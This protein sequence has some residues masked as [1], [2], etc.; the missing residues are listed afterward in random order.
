MDI[1]EDEVVDHSIAIYE[2]LQI[3]AVAVSIQ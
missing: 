2:A 1:P 3:G